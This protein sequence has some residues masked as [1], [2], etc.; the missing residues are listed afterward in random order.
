MRTAC[1]ASPKTFSSLWERDASTGDDLMLPEGTPGAGTSLSAG[2]HQTDA[3]FARVYVAHAVTLVL[4]GLSGRA[5]EGLP[6]VALALGLVRGAEVRADAD[7]VQAHVIL[8]ARVAV[9][10]RRTV[11]NERT[12]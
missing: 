7:A 3:L 4:E 8:R 12:C 9:L 2:D 6:P 11:I 10:T 5:D 1:S